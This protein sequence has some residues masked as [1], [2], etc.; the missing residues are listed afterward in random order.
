LRSTS[1]GNAFLEQARHVLRYA[2]VARQAARHA[3]D[4]AIMRRRPRATIEL[5]A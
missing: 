2:Q 4:Q 5:A 1:A 3:R